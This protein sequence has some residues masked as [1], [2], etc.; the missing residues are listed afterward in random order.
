MRYTTQCVQ[1]SKRL[2]CD[3]SLALSGHPDDS[4]TQSVNTFELT[5][6][7]IG[8]FDSSVNFVLHI[9]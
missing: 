2:V 3:M 7:T 9:C 8:L 4:R 1:R 6:N 5:C